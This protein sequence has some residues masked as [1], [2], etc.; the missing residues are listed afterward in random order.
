MSFWI[1]QNS[2][3]QD[4]LKTGNIILV[5]LG[6]FLALS[7]LFGGFFI[8]DAGE[9]GVVFNKFSGMKDVTYTEG[10]HFKVPFVESATKFE[11]R[12]K[13][14]EAHAS[15]ASK[16]LQIV[17]TNVALNYHLDVSRV[18]WLY[19]MIG[20]EYE[21]RIISP[22]VQEV[23]KA[24]T[25]KYNA[26]DLI[27]HRENVKQDIKEALSSRLSGSAIILDDMSITNFDFSEE[28]NKAIEQKVVSEQNALKEQNNLKVVEFQVQQKIEQARGEAESIK[29]INQELQRSPQYVS[30]LMVQKWD[31]VAPLYMGGNAMLTLPMGA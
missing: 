12:T 21:A 20:K 30:L 3:G 22:S 23:V 24:V 9:R 10:I 15:S 13:V 6:L 1:K 26:E 18:N 29:L 25:A 16:D 4:E 7:I 2:Q 28:F 5:V 27:K 17:V 31:G 8:V 14:Y 11:V 19:Q